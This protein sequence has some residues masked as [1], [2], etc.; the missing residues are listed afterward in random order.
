MSGSIA[1]TPHTVGTG[2]GRQARSR[3]PPGPPV[4]TVLAIARAGV[5]TSPTHCQSDPHEGYG[6]GRHHR[7]RRRRRQRPLSPR[8]DR[9]DRRAPHREERVD[10]RLDLARRRRHAHVQRRGEHLAA[11]E[12]HDRPLSR[13][14]GIVGAVVRPAP[15]RRPDAGGHAGR[16]RQPEAHLLPRPLPRHGNRDDHARGGARAQP[17]HR[18]EALHR[19]VVAS[20]RRPLRSVRHDARLRQG[21]PQA[22]RVGRTFYTRARTEAACGRQL[23]RRH[24]QGHGARRARRELRGPVGARSRPDG[25][26]RVAG[27]RDGAPLPAHRRHPRAEGPRRRRSSTR[28]TTPARSTCARSGAGR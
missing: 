28:P 18:H 4:G 1:G 17:A 8:E 12:V 15:E 23:G 14:R 13:D 19:R 21:G 7:R 25:R 10:V 11:A 20:R 9:L 6:Q 27:A 3:R 24:R 5:V 22:R 16:T 2:R 26:H